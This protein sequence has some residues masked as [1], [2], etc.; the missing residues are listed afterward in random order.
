MVDDVGLGHELERDLES[1]RVLEVDGDVALAALAAEERLACEPHAVTGRGLDLDHVGPDVA[2]DHR[3]ERPGEVLTEV[4]DAN[5][6]ECSHQPS[7]PL[8][9]AISAS[10]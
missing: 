7:S 4:D 3:T 8:K 9:P 6:F 5:P 10:L 1:V 2:E